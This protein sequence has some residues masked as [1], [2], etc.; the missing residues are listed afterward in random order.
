M[1]S[2]V[3]SMLGKS[4]RERNISFQTAESGEMKARAKVLETALMKLVKR[5]VPKTAKKKTTTSAATETEAT[6]AAPESATVGGDASSSPVVEE[7]I[8]PTPTPVVPG[9]E[10]QVPIQPRDEL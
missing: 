7:T 8:V 10:E 9:E 2:V 5:K 6:V 4:Y 3:S 1:K